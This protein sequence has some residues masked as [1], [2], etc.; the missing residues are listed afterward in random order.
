MNNSKIWLVVNPTVGIPI[1]LG[2][3]AVG[4]FSVH[5]AVVSNSDW[6]GE[7]ISGLEMTSEMASADTKSAVQTAS[8]PVT[9]YGEGQRIQITMPDGSTTWAVIEAEETTLASALLPR[10]SN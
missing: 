8:A 9:S 10:S 6:V 3:V 1:F 4:S 5:V 2:A 7:F